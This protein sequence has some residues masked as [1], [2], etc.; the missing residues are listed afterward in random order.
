MP[1]DVERQA[2]GALGSDAGQLLQL[3]DEPGKRFGE[4]QG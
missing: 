4:R 2:L 1:E 3:F